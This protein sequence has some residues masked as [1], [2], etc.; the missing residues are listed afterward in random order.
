MIRSLTVL[1]VLV[2][3]GVSRGALLTDF[4]ASYALYQQCAMNGADFDSD[5]DIDGMDL[6]Q[7]QRGVG[8]V[9]QFINPFGDADRNGFVN[10]LDVNHWKGQFGGDL[11]GLPE[12]ECFKLF[13]DPQGIVSGSATLVIDVPNPISGQ[14]RIALGPD[15]RLVDVHPQYTAQVLQQNIL[16]LPGRQRLE[17]N[18]AFNANNPTSLPSGPVT[19]F[20]FQAPDLLSQLG[21]AGIITQVD[22][23]PGNTI[24]IFDTDTGDTITFDHTQ[25]IDVNPS[26]APPLTLDVNT[27]TGAMSLR[28]PAT[29]PAL[30]PILVTQYQIGSRAGALSPSG[31]V[32]LEDTGLPWHEAAGVS[33]L[34]LSE[35]S[36]GGALE[37]VN[38]QSQPLGNAYSVARSARDLRFFYTTPQGSRIC[39]DVNYFASPVVAAPEPGAIVMA[40]LGLVWA[41]FHRRRAAA[42]P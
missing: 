2:S 3:C 13:L 21:L 11:T 9:G 18:I 4:A 31:W 20:G 27:A 6:L 28:S 32:S 19:L 39:G 34:F 35:S 26:I 1:I 40:L 33:T 24:A 7:W 8:M 5:E 22:F 38:G 42:T 29:T 25:L 15:T 12:S 37:V 16:V 41:T 36:Q 23:R 17:V 30:P 14:T 10:Q